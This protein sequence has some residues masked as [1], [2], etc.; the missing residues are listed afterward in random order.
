MLLSAQQM[1]ELLLN[2]DFELE[3]NEDGTLSLIDLQRAYLGGIGD[4]TFNNYAEV[5]Q[6]LDMYAHDY[7][8]Y[9][10]WEALHDEYG[11]PFDSQW[12]EQDNTWEE[13]IQVARDLG[14]GD[15]GEVTYLNW[16]IQGGLMEN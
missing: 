3:V 1:E 15:Y 12:N 8:V 9:P 11:E 6:R 14:C 4:E 5:L 2:L 16:Y 7:W 13:L 10:L